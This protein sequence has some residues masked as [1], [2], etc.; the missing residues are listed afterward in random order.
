LEPISGKGFV[1]AGNEFPKDKRLIAWQQNGIWTSII[2][3]IRITI[4]WSQ[5]DSCKAID[6]Y[7]DVTGPS[8]RDRY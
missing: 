6:D 5:P 7:V 4:A 3:N 8:V 1:L 2:R